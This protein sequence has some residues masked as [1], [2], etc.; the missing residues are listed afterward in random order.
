MATLVSRDGG[1]PAATSRPASGVSIDPYQLIWWRELNLWSR[2]D[3][4]DR[5]AWL[6][7]DRHPDAI[8]FTH[9]DGEPADGHAPVPERQMTHPARL[10]TVCGGKVAGGLTRDAIA[11]N[12]STGPN[13]RRPKPVSLRAIVAALTTYGQPVRPAGLLPGAPRAER[14]AEALDRDARRRRNEE[15]REFADMIGRP[16]LARDRSGRARYTRELEILFAEYQQNQAAREAA[17][18]E[19]AMAS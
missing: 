11:K 19:P 9:R 2:Q 17:A 3:L 14:S 18:A 10:C 4:A 1:A 7:L 15:M 13:R 5:V 8:G 16:E 6:F 12:E